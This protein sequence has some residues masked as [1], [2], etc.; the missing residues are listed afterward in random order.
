M[1]AEIEATTPVSFYHRAPRVPLADFVELFWYWSGHPRMDERERILP[2]PNLEFVIQLRDSHPYA[3]VSGPRSE[4]FIIDRREASAILGIHFKPGGAFPFLGCAFGELHNTHAS[5]VELWG[6]KRP[7]RLL[8]LLHAA[9]TVDLKFDILER[10]LLWIADRPLKHHAAVTFAV[11]KFREDPGLFSSER[12]AREANMSQRRFIELFRDEVGM[13]PKLFCR[14]QRFQNAINWINQQA[15]VDWVDV[16]LSH[17]YTDQSH[18]IH[19]FR[20]FSGLK[21]SEYLDLRTE[22]L[23]HVRFRE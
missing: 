5:L 14:V 10:W 23:N 18:F 17:G 21:P 12:L 11:K 20:E 9:P 4:S 15:E 1:R 8:E 3:G 6:E 16:A 7:R 19:D 22:S 2:M 13:T